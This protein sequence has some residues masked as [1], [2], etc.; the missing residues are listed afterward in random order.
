M[1]RVHPKQ[2]RWPQAGSS[3]H[4]RIA[5]KHTCAAGWE[6]TGAAGWKR[7]ASSRSVIR[8]G[9]LL[10][11]LGRAGWRCWVA[12]LGGGA[13]WRGR[14]G[15]PALVH[16]LALTL[17]TPCWSSQERVRR[18]AGSGLGRAAAEADR[19]AFLLGAI[20][21]RPCRRRR[22]VLDAII[23]ELAP[24]QHA[25][26]RVA[27][28]RVASRRVASRRVAP[29]RVPLG[30]GDRCREKEPIVPVVLVQSA[31]LAR[32]GYVVADLD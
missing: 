15:T 4:C 5:Q 16:A 3:V 31:D 6:Q 7:C 23:R 22:P 2:K 32:L 19:A 21:S 25:P 24:P 20:P 13:G 26:R 27:S 14:S 18:A 1:G 30:R 29:R 17:T 10:L 12:V 11:A 28:R 9:C 8:S